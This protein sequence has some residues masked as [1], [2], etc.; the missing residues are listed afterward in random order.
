MIGPLRTQRYDFATFAVNGFGLFQ[1]H[2]KNIISFPEIFN[3]SEVIPLDSLSYLGVF[4]TK[5]DEY[6]NHFLFGWIQFHI[7]GD[8]SLLRLMADSFGIQQQFSCIIPDI[9]R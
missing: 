1:Q 7:I 9:F 8:T 5:Q 3:E 2:P 6:H 4:R